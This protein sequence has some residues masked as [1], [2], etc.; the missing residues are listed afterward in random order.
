MRENIIH[1]NSVCAL[2]KLTR[3]GYPMELYRAISDKIDSTLNGRFLEIGAG[4]GV[5]SKEIY[6]VFGKKMLLL[7]PSLESCNILKETFKYNNDIEI[8]NCLFEDFRTTEKFDAIFAPSSFH[9]LEDTCKYKLVSELLKKGGFLIIYCNYYSLADKLILGEISSINQIYGNLSTFNVESQQKQIHKQMEDINRS[10]FQI[11]ESQVYKNIKRYTIK[12]F[13]S[14]LKTFV[15]IKNKSKDYIQAIID[16]VGRNYDYVDVEI[17]T[18]L[19]ITKRSIG[20]IT[21]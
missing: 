14:F 15:K 12:D 8:I 4:T 7:E 6:S 13:T 10:N 17:L 19:F 9:W 18:C 11:I 20:D 1:F 16:I 2:Y 21:N 5:S 3:P